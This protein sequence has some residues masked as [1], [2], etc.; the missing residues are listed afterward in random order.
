MNTHS[1]IHLVV[2][3]AGVEEIEVLYPPGQRQA[4]WLLCLQLLPQLERLE[5][6]LTETT[7]VSL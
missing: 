4:A 1:K 7:P 6:T 2:S 5:R 3:G